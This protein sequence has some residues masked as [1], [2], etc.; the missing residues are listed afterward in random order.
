MTWTRPVGAGRGHVDLAGIGFGIG[1]EFGDG[2]GRERRAG[3]HDERIAPDGAD[4]R[5]VT[6]EIERQMR[7]ERRVDQIRRGDEKQR[8]A[9]GRRAGDRLRGDVGAGAG[10]VL[11]DEILA[12]PRRQPL[13]E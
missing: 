5:Y 9:V 10:T 8:V 11:D 6:D 3:H 13:A 1:D 4:R 2:L 7:I 12:E